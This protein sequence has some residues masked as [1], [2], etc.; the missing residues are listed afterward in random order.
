LGALGVERSSL[1]A[2]ASRTSTVVATQICG[3]A[4]GS[5]VIGDDVIVYQ[6]DGDSV[7][8]VRVLHE[9]RRSRL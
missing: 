2:P 9:S 5:F 6:V 1:E 8:I 7:L 3:L 4:V